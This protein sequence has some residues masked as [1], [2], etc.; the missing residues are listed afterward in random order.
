MSELVDAVEEDASLHSVE[1]ETNLSFSKVDDRVSVYTEEAGLMRR[2]LQHPHFEV[3]SLRGVNGQR[4]APR[5]FEDGSITGVDGGIPIES[6]V[7]QTSLRATSQHSA[8]V[9]EGVLRREVIV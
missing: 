9:P 4:V 6:L 3:D 5:D 2:L 1:K 7:L 8:V